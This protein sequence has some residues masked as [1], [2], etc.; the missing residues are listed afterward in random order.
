M[1]TEVLNGRIRWIITEFSPSRKKY[2]SDSFPIGD[3]QWKLQ[4]YPNGAA[5]EDYVSLYLA[6]A[7]PKKPFLSIGTLKSAVKPNGWSQSIKL[8]FSIIDQLSNLAVVKGLDHEFGT[9]S[10]AHGFAAFMLV[11]KF[12]DP[13]SGYVLNDR[14]VIELTFAVMQKDEGLSLLLHA[15]IKEYEDWYEIVVNMPGTRIEEITVKLVDNEKALLVS[16]TQEKKD[17]NTIRYMCAERICGELVRKFLITEDMDVNMI[18]A[19]YK[20]GLLNVIIN[21]LKQKHPKTIDVK[22]FSSLVTP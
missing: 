6:L 4:L 11:R 5:N 22:R 8:T 18:S 3:Q 17:E 15:D 7:V 9:K 21:K 14:C 19:A 20:E 2:E 12:N 1:V 13:G 16:C 10:S